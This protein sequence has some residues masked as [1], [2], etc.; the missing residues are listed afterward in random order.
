MGEKRKRGRN[1]EEEEHKERKKEKKA[2]K[3]KKKN[4]KKDRESES[5]DEDKENKKKKKKSKKRKDKESEGEEEEDQEENKEGEAM[6]QKSLVPYEEA[7]E[8]KTNEEDGQ[9]RAEQ[10]KEEEKP[11]IDPTKFINSFS[12]TVVEEVK[13]KL[14]LPTLIF[15]EKTVELAPREEVKPETEV[16]EAKIDVHK[17]NTPEPIANSSRAQ[18]LTTYSKKQQ[19]TTAERPSRHKEA[20]EEGSRHEETKG[21]VSKKEVEAAA[22]SKWD[23]EESFTG[24]EFALQLNVSKDE[25]N[26]ME[27]ESPQKDLKEEPTT[28]LK[29]ALENIKEKEKGGVVRKK[30]RS[31][32]SGSDHELEDPE[33][34]GKKEQRK[35]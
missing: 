11:K 15:N 25:F 6:E 13:P 17:E 31:T 28:A 7:E 24:E 20:K 21:E 8:P 1:G 2:K 5:E 32:K 14:K 3:S 18:N 27:M 23:L 34:V 19:D 30:R 9:E 12:E 35:T 22:P 33:L 29:K 10:E 4:K 16:S 26:G